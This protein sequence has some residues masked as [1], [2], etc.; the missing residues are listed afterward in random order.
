MPRPDTHAMELAQ[1]QIDKLWSMSV[2]QAPSEIRRVMEKAR[3]FGLA[4]ERRTM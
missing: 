3:L 2:E 4:T 1:D